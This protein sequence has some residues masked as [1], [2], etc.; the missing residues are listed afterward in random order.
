VWVDNRPEFTAQPFVDR[1]AEHCI[2]W[3]YIQPGKPDQNA[4]IER[5]TAR[6]ARTS[7]PPI[8]A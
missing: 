8:I 6:I 7:S 2:A 3:D 1:C 4:Y 5:F